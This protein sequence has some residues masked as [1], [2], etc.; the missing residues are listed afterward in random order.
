ME[1]KILILEEKLKDLKSYRKDKIK[2][3]ETLDTE[4]NWIKIQLENFS[5]NKRLP[6][7][8]DELLFFKNEKMSNLVIKEKYI[9]TT[10]P[11]TAI[12]SK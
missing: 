5:L 2:Q 3:I 10:N 12:N 1:D 9:N 6:F 7:N 4:I 11:N 8:N